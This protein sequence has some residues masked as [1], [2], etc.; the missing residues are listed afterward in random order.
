V[1]PQA[2]AVVNDIKPSPLRA[3]NARGRRVLVCA[4]V[5]T[6]LHWLAKQRRAQVWLAWQVTGWLQGGRD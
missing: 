4:A 3:S 1:P 5:S 2:R 6:Q